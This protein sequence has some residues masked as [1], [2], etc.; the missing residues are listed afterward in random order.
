MKL[1]VGGVPTF[2][3]R[4]RGKW[5]ERTQQRDREVWA[6]GGVGERSSSRIQCSRGCRGE[7]TTRKWGR[8]AAA[9]VRV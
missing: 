2:D 1:P 6:Q 3:V 8:V 7:V 9:C 4:E 5:M